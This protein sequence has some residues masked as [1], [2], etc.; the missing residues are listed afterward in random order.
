MIN[1]AAVNTYNNF[2]VIDKAKI[3]E[4][5]SMTVLNMRLNIGY[6]NININIGKNIK[7]QEEISL[8]RIKLDKKMKETIEETKVIAQNFHKLNIF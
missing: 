4:G 1:R 5:I 7:E 8:E 2:G 6:F 3:R